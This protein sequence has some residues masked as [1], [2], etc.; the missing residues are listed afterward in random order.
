VIYCIIPMDPFVQ[1]PAILESASDF[2]FS[3]SNCFLLS[4]IV[5]SSGNAQ[6]DLD[7]D[8][9]KRYLSSKFPSAPRHFEKP[10]SGLGR[11]FN[12]LTIASSSVDPGEGPTFISIYHHTA[13][14]LF[15]LI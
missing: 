14:I 6:L 12:Q 10:R 2:L 5:L 8:Q 3:P 4:I 9:K 11:H 15:H 7:G 1:C 13:S